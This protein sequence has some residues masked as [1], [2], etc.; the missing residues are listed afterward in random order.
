MLIG[1][2]DQPAA[3]FEDG[4]ARDRWMAAGGFVVLV[5]SFCPWF[6][7]HPSNCIETKTAWTGSSL[8]CAAVLSGV[9]ATLVWFGAV[10]GL[11]DRNRRLVAAG[12]PLAAPRL[13]GEQWG[14]LHEGGAG[15]PLRHI[16]TTDPPGEPLPAGRTPAPP[17]P[18]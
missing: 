15:A 16:Y 11:T 4:S 14:D 18:H 6:T 1:M 10:K 9:V 13:P 8:W 2:G 17:P 12:L 7:G 3:G 5:A